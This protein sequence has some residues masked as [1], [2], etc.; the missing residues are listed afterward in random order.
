MSNNKYMIISN[1]KKKTPFKFVA[2]II[3]S[4]TGGWHRTYSY[5]DSIQGTVCCNYIV[6]LTSPLGTFIKASNDSV[7]AL[8]PTTMDVVIK[9]TFVLTFKQYNQ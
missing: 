1:Q 7:L 3:E 5:C 2:N 8:V 6:M 4:N 9:Y